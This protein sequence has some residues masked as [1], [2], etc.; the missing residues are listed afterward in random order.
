MNRMSLR[1][2]LDHPWL[3][4]FYPALPPSSRN[5][6]LQASSSSAKAGV[7]HDFIALHIE[8]SKGPT[9]GKFGQREGSRGAPLQRRSDIL[10]QAAEGNRAVPEPLPEMIANASAKEAKRGKRVRNNL[11]PLDEEGE[12]EYDPEDSGPPAT[13]SSTTSHSSGGP[14]SKKA[15][16][17][18]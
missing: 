13:R 7:T 9:G 17:E 14:R 12:V 10:S 8:P 4:S 3:R 18:A 1:E 16:T 5:R 2:A 11:T 6:P 15:R